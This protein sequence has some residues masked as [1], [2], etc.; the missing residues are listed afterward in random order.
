[1]PIVRYTK[2]DAERDKLETVVVDRLLTTF[3]TFQVPSLIRSFRAKL[4][5]TSILVAFDP[6]YQK[7]QTN[8]DSKLRSISV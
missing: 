5:T 7:C 6:T 8:V 2:Q 4:H 3:A 1:M